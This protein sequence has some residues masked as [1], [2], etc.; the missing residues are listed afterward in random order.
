M[1]YQINVPDTVQLSDFELTRNLAALLF[2]RGIL[3]SGQA[4]DMVGLT[5]RSF[6]EMVGKY[7]VSIFQYDEDEFLE[8]IDNF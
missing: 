5:K 4:A 7:G 8:E 2:G 1:T 6:L 3:S